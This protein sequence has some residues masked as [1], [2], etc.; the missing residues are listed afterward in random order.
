MSTNIDGKI[1]YTIKKLCQ[2]TTV[3]KEKLIK[4]RNKTS[5]R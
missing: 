1:V 3:S 4:Q 5:F 2:D